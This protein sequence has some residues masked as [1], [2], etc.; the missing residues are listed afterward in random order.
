MLVLIKVL[1]YCIFC[2]GFHFLVKLDVFEVT[3]VFWKLW[4]S[5]LSNLLRW[6]FHASLWSP[7]SIYAICSSTSSWSYRNLEIGVFLKKCLKKI[8]NFG[9]FSKTLPQIKIFWMP[10]ALWFRGRAFWCFSFLD[11]SIDFNKNQKLNNLNK[12][13]NTGQRN[14]S[15]NIKLKN[16]CINNLVGSKFHCSRWIV[17]KEEQAPFAWCDQGWAKFGSN[18]FAIAL[19]RKFLAS[20][21]DIVS[22]GGLVYM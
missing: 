1:D 9:K 21:W 12:P 7:K 14:F 2:K 22:L 13:P 4:P 15:K 5:M 16:F 17:W 20:L 3:V 10:N 18:Q 11:T 6:Y 19:N 8:K